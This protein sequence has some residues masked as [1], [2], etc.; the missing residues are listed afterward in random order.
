[1]D[2]YSEEGS[3]TL[4][5]IIEL[6]GK[7]SD[8]LGASLRA[9]DFSEAYRASRCWSPPDHGPQKFKMP[10]SPPSGVRK[11]VGVQV[12]SEPPQSLSDSQNCVQ[13][14][15]VQM[16][17]GEHSDLQSGGYAGRKCTPAGRRATSLPCPPK[18]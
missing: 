1:M 11:F 14:G 16:K 15:N 17:K 13:N 3:I 7:G 18:A 10:G 5:G 4:A 2:L 6:P 12:G 9:F 8:S